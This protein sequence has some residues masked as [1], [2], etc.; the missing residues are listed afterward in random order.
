MVEMVL[1]R[2]TLEH[3]KSEAS[4]VV[5]SEAAFGGGCHWCT[6]AV[7]DHAPGVLTVRQGFASGP[8][9]DDAPSEAALVTWGEE[10]TL[11]DLIRIHL[12]THSAGSDHA[13]RARYRSAIYVTGS[14]QAAL[15]RS[16]LREEAAQR[17]PLVTRVLP[18][19]AWRDS[20]PRYQRYYRTRPDAP[21]CRVHIAPKLARLRA[22]REA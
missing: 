2:A 10:V 13:L 22:S 19:A 4:E 1:P 15:A 18:L 5:T 16:V 14:A 20:P 12:D 7:F 17:G 21:F 9:P 8:P 11:E 3:I 6:E